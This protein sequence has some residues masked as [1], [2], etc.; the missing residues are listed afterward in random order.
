MKS[1]FRN[2]KYVEWR[3]PEELHAD[4]IEWLSDL[5]FVKV[6]QSFL[7]ELIKE[8]TLNL[9]SG[10]TYAKSKEIVEKLSKS[11]KNVEVLYNKVLAH[12]N[13]LQILIDEIKQEKREEK[14]K[15]EHYLLHAEIAVFMGDFK[16]VKNEIFE[17]IK[18]IMRQNKQKRLLK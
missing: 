1:K 16:D 4:T 2:I 7:E 14:F 18:K 3:N 6:E 9:I 8:N 17:L 15:Q 10:D 5:E 13:G 11:V 12:S